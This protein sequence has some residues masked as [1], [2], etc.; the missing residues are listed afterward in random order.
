MRIYIYNIIMRVC[1][2]MYNIMIINCAVCELPILL[3]VLII[4]YTYTRGL[5]NPAE[6]H[7]RAA[8]DD[9]WGALRLRWLRQ[10][11]LQSAQTIRTTHFVG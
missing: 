3:C 6:G 10:C 2:A 1:N 9:E 4:F 5:E 8:A 7:S 11:S